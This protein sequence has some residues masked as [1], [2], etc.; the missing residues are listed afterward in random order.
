MINRYLKINFN[1]FGFP[2]KFLTQEMVNEYFKKTNQIWSIPDEFQTQEMWNTFIK[3]KKYKIVN[4]CIVNLH[5][6][7]KLRTQ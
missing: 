1:I 4:N 7:E 3:S 2:H 5:D 6:K